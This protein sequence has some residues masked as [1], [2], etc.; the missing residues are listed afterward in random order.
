VQRLHS[1][2]DGHEDLAGL[3]KNACT[4]ASTSKELVAY[5]AEYAFMSTEIVLARKSELL[6]E[7]LSVYA[8]T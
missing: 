7:T 2:I 8:V 1:L 5:F 4:L 3:E 6:Y